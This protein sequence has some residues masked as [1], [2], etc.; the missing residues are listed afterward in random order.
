MAQFLPLHPFPFLGLE[1]LVTAPSLPR[2]PVCRAPPP[3]GGEK[4]DKEKS[5]Q[6]WEA[7]LTQPVLS[8]LA[9][10]FLG[11]IHPSFLIHS[12][13]LQAHSGSQALEIRLQASQ[14]PA[15]PT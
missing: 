15:T 11:W 5:K 8:T 6:C 2:H 4:G 10:V 12:R 3:Q 7:D 14:T 9:S 13:A 1:A